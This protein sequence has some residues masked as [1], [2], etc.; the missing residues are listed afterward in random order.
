MKA[1]PH[2]LQDPDAVDLGSALIIAKNQA[3]ESGFDLTNH[4]IQVRESVDESGG[5]FLR[6]DF[7]PPRLPNVYR[8]GGGFTVD[9]NTEDGT[10]RRAQFG[11]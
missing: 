9:V 11:Q 4:H 7:L 10:V 2:I 3:I 8:R 5:R 1:D 6:I